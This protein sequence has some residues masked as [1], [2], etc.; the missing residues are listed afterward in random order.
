MKWAGAAPAGGIGWPRRADR[1]DL[2]VARR[3]DMIPTM[4][5]EYSDVDGRGIHDRESIPKEDL[6][7]V[8]E[9]AS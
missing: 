1:F 6:R 9:L 8:G 7:A 5:D 4:L 2:R 3:E